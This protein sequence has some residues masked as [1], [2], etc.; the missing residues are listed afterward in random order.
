MFAQLYAA[1]DCH[2]QAFGVCAGRWINMAYTAA[3]TAG[4]FRKSGLI[5][6]KHERFNSQT[7]R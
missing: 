2:R 1:P 3:Q 4:H 7:I 5:S 6:W